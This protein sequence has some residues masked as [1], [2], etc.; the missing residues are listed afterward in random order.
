MKTNGGIFGGTTKTLHADLA[1]D[2][3]ICGFP[4]DAEGGID[5]GLLSIKVTGGIRLRG[6]A[7]ADEAMNAQDY[8][9]NAVPFAEVVGG[10]EFL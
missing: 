3:G 1:A 4:V 2:G 10:F 6:Q 7:C 5:A 9:V 8:S